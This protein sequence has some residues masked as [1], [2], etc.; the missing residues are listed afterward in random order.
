MSDEHPRE[1]TEVDR[2]AKLLMEVW[3]KAEPKSDVTL[4]PVSY[5]ASFVDM[6]RAVVVATTEREWLIED[7]FAALVEMVGILRAVG[8]FMTPEQQLQ[9]RRAERV[10]AQ[11]QVT[12]SPK[13][14]KAPRFPS[15]PFPTT[16]V[17]ASTRRPR[18]G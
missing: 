10:I 2:I 16:L 4:Y 8:G 5:I 7:G 11:A 15:E 1:P 17:G 6:A 3:A 13:K 14:R 18:G 9:L 12:P